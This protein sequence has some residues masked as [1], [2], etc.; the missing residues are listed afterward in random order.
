VTHDHDSTAPDD[1]AAQRGGPD[2]R[3]RMSDISF[4]KQSALARLMTQEAARRAFSTVI[5]RPSAD[6]R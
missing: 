5:S 6:W 1:A 3:T 4:Y 2:D